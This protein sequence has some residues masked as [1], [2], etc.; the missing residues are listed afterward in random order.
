MEIYKEALIRVSL[1]FFFAF[2]SRCIM[3]GVIV[4]KKVIGIC[5]IIY[6]ALIVYAFVWSKKLTERTFAKIERDLES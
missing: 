6:T 4:M 5:A 2:E 1:Y 3:K